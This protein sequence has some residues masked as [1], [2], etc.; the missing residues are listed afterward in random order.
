MRRFGGA[1]LTVTGILACPCHLVFTLP[2]L[3]TLLAGTALGSF[4]THNSSFIYIGA[5]IY[6]VV[7]LVLGI[8]FLLGVQQPK[9]RANAGCSTCPPVDRETRGQEQISW[10]V[11]VPAQIREEE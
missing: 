9:W 1:L 2:L 8:R 10:Q 11:S 6:F 5:G 3:A 4:L 7:A